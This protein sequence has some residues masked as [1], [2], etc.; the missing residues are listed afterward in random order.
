[1]L[2]ALCILVSTAALGW[3]AYRSVSPLPPAPVGCAPL[4]VGGWLLVG[5]ILLGVLARGKKQA[6][7]LDAAGTA[8]SSGE[9]PTKEK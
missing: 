6:W 4:L 3:V 9:V 7:L 8:V 1:M 2:H 5:L